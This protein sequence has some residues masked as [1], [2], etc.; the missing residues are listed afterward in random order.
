MTWPTDYLNK[1]ICGDCLEVMKG[2]PDGGV[3]VVVTSIPFNVGKD[4]GDSYNDN[5]TDSEYI[6][7]LNLW[8]SEICRCAANAI[9][10]FTSTKYMGEVKNLLPGFVQWIFWH[11]PNIVSPSLKKPWIPTITPIAMSWTNGRRKMKNSEINC[12]TFDLIVAASP[13]SNFNGDKKRVHVAQ[14][15]VGA[16]LPLISRTDGDVIF[17]PFMGSGTTGVAAKLLGRQFIGIEISEKYCEIARK[18]IDQTLVNRKLN[19]QE[20]RP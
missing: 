7:K 11:R 19:F 9:Y 10:I 2:I 5:M 1:V 6:G 13:Q 4:Y 3:D 20:A 17:D 8:F 15:P 18:R 16:Y 14:D 12:N